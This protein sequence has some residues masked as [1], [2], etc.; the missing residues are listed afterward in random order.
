MIKVYL[1][2]VRP[3]AHRHHEIAGLGDAVGELA[4]FHPQPDGGD[5]PIH[6]ART[7]GRMRIEPT[8]RVNSISRARFRP[9]A[10]KRHHRCGAETTRSGQPEPSAAGF[11]GSDGQIACGDEL[12]SGGGGNPLDF[13]D[14]RLESTAA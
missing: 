14:H 9:M 11:L 1:R 6:E 8:R 4:S 12:A 13:G 2:I 5:H 3:L 10:P 7:G